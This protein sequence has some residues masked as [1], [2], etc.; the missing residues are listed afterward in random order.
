MAY[1]DDIGK[2]ESSLNAIIVIMLFLSYGGVHVSVNSHIV[3]TPGTRLIGDRF[4]DSMQHRE[5]EPISRVSKICSNNPNPI[6]S[7]WGGAHVFRSSSF[8]ST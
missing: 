1:L 4:I 8:L 3:R 7:N 5:Q 6:Y 2:K